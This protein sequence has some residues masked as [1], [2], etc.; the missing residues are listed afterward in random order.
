MLYKFYV[1]LQ[2]ILK[3]TYP[4]FFNLTLLPP[5]SL[6]KLLNPYSVISKG[7]CK[8]RPDFIITI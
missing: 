2:K 4:L 7:I 1:I 6:D 5:N 8:P 3:E